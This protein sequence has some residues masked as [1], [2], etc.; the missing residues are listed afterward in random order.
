MVSKAI[1][2]GDIDTNKPISL[3]KEDIIKSIVEYKNKIASTSISNIININELD[4]MI[5]TLR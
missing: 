3:V 1:K 5:N 2:L 4:D